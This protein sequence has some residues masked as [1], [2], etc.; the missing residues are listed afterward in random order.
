MEPAFAGSVVA[1]GLNVF[2]EDVSVMTAEPVNFLLQ[3]NSYIFREADVAAVP[4]FTVL[5]DYSVYP[6]A[7]GFNDVLAYHLAVQR[8]QFAVPIDDLLLR[9]SMGRHNH[10]VSVAEGRRVP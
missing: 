3:P 4:Q 5:F 6:L 10:I 7:V 8:R 1:V 9:I 2:I